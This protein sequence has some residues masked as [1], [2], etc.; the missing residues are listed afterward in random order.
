MEHLSSR[1]AP[2]QL[3]HA[4]LGLANSVDPPAKRIMEPF[5]DTDPGDGAAGRI[6]L[7]T[8]RARR[9]PLRAQQRPAPPRRHRPE[10]LD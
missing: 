8:S 4:A 1:G 7:V 6:V 5:D 2:R 9:P 3:Q 10:L